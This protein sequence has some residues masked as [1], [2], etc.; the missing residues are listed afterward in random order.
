MQ[1]YLILFVLFTSQKEHD[2]YIVMFN[3]PDNTDP[4]HEQM[5][6]ANNTL[7]TKALFKNT[8]KI[9][10]T[11]ING[12]I[13]NLTEE[14]K[15]KLEMDHN[16]AVI[17]KDQEINVAEYFDYKI[18]ISFEIVPNNSKINVQNSAPWG[19]SRISSGKTFKATTKFVYPSSA[20]EGVDVYVI[21]SGI[22]I[23]HPEFHGSAKWGINL[24]E[25]SDDTDEHGHG[26]HCAGTIAGRRMGIA[27]KA[28][29]TA[30]KVLDRFGTGKISRV[31]LGVDFVI[32]RH[33]S[34]TE[35]L[36]GFNRE[37]FLENEL[38]EIADATGGNL[39]EE[40]KFLRSLTDFLKFEE[41]KPK[42]VVNMSVGG[43]RS[44]A[45]EFAVDYATKLGIHFSV[46]A[47]NDHEDACLFSPG[48]SKGAMTV[49]AST[50]DDTIAFFSNIGKCVDIYAPGLQIKSSWKDH[51]I[52]VASGTSMAAPHVSGAMALY[53]GVKNYTPHDLKDKLFEDSFEVIKDEEGDE[54]MLDFWPL[55][56]IFNSDKN[57]FKLVSISNLNKTVESETE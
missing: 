5:V 10:K 3:T 7:R 57:M 35:E 51:S 42:S 49:G 19:I 27:K 16:V 23:D 21:D 33:N 22:E 13:A 20:G 47:G 18:P 43:L 41:K 39:K 11:F 4:F 32:K 9:V 31:I 34:K 46:A 25:G 29:L 54:D 55:K 37:R 50:R 15:N 26:T 44:R 17:E 56:Y 28:N 6:Y 30:V 14:T 1:I 2:D 12:Y 52:K 40:S 8:E 48:A 36:D 45:L 53:L 24:V 38:N